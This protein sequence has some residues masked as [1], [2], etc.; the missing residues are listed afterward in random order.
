[1]NLLQKLDL[2]HLR[3][4]LGVEDL[5]GVV[6]FKITTNQLFKEHLTAEERLQSLS[7]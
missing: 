3:E 7:L 2:T 1:M 6:I 5:K 4:Q